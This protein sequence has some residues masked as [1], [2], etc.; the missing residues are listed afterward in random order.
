[1]PIVMTTIFISSYLGAWLCAT[2]ICHRIAYKDPQAHFAPEMSFLHRFDCRFHSRRFNHRR[3]A[4]FDSMSISLL[5]FHFLNDRHIGK[6]LSLTNDQIEWY[7]AQ[8]DKCIWKEIHNRYKIDIQGLAR[9]KE[10]KVV[11][12]SNT[13]IMSLLWKSSQL[14][15]TRFFSFFHSYNLSVWSRMVQSS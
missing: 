10:K 12:W 14:N 1:M 2:T 3:Y 15:R 5:S 7:A 13:V 4:S 6:L 11:E 8:L 9:A